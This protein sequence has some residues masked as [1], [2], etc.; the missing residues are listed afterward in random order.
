M[1]VSSY[2]HEILSNLTKAQ[3]KNY[4]LTFNVLYYNSNIKPG[5]EFPHKVYLYGIKKYSKIRQLDDLNTFDSQ[6]IFKNCTAGKYS[7]NN[8]IGSII[9]LLP[10]FVPAGK[11]TKLESDGIDS[12][13][14]NSINLI[15]DRDFNRSSSSSSSKSTNSNSTDSNYKTNSS[16]SSSKKWLPWVI[17]ICVVVF[18]VAMV[19]IILACKK[20]DSEDS[21]APNDTTVEKNNNSSI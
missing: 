12:N 21:S 1:I 11:Y 19:I 13:P 15:L 10:D 18:L 17:V 5:N 2:N 3:K 16:S 8:A 20:N 9:C 7:T 4:S 6:I 14:Q